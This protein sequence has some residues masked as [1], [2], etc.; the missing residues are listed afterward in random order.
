MKWQHNSKFPG[1]FVKAGGRLFVDQDVFD[2]IIEKVLLTLT[3]L[4][5][6]FS[7]HQ[8]ALPSSKKVYLLPRNQV[9]IRGH[10]LAAISGLNHADQFICLFT[11]KR[12][13]PLRDSPR[14]QPLIYQYLRPTIS[15]GLSVINLRY[16]L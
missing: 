1:L 3:H 11:D 10:R 2:G 9:R 16:L 13:E 8:H 12:T 15:A 4:D 5:M 6:K 7:F 14:P